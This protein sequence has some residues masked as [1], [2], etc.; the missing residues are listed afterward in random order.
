MRL[1]GSVAV[2]LLLAAG[3]AL[4]EST[5]DRFF[6]TGAVRVLILSGRNNHDWRTTTPFLRRVLMA[7]GR[8]DTRVD[9]EPAGLTPEALAAYDAVVV[10]YNGPRWGATAENALENFVKSGK[11]L[12][13]VHGASYAFGEMELLGDNH[14]AT[15]IHE[16]PWPAWERMVG[17]A[18]QMNP[19][20]GHAPRH[21]FTVQWKDREHPIAAGLAATFT[22]DDEIY[23]QLRLESNI[24]VLAT[25]YDD[26]AIGGTGHDEPVLWTVAYGSGR[27]F[28]TTLG[29]DVAAMMEPG[30]MASFA[31]G[32][33][34]A[35][36]GAV[37]IAG[38]VRLDAQAEHPIRA[39]LVTGGHDH[40]ASFYSVFRDYGDIRVNIDPHPA[41]FRHDI[42]GE[43]DV[44]VLYD[45]VQEVGEEQR[46]N[47]KDYVEGGGG[48]VV[49]HH[50]LADFN[51]WAWWWH[52]VVGGRYLLKADA[53]MPA[54]TY[55][56][57]V[58]QRV[59]VVT[60]HPITHGL[61]PMHLVDEAYH[62]VWVSPDS[63]VL[64]HS[65]TALSDGPVAWIGPFQKA[66]VV[67]IELGHDHQAH[68]YPPFR[69]LV[70]NAIAWAGSR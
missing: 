16:A 61:P 66:R 23:H 11:G 22:G 5:I 8:F 34:W 35:A 65:D 28:H 62:G 63:K 67:Y 14:V 56:H 68:D 46:K 12:V 40:E 6:H 51:D 25:A 33:E 52:D 21:I 30:F 37:T 19:K 4:G 42:R 64:L 47:L 44:V 55:Q 26:A 2:V 43:Y 38:A 36:T 48:L 49:L 7:T 53:G 60:D 50:A 54:S 9:E 10:D 59:T 39:L 69:Q 24:H 13:I 27:V 70:H 31:R 17:A 1:T 20:S 57:D 18:W 41:A 45:M 29:H 32:T 3:L 15:G 58:E